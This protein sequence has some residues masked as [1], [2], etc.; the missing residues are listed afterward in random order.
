MQLFMTDTG[1]D[2]ARKDV[3]FT[4]AA[5]RAAGSHDDLVPSLTGL[6]A[7]WSAI[8]AERQ[9]HEDATEDANTFVSWIDDTLDEGVN[10][11]ATRL[12]NACN[13]D[14]TKIMF[15][16]FFP[17]TPSEIVRLGL[18]AEVTR[19]AKW[20]VV[21]KEI[22]LPAEVD[23][24][25]DD[26]RDIADRGDKAVLARDAAVTAQGAISVRTQMWR[27]EANNVRRAVE[28]ALDHYANTN[29]LARNYSA[30]FFPK[31]AAPKKK[32]AAAAPAPVPP[33]RPSQPPQ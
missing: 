13:R 17:E 3:R 14:R 23:K 4:L 33:A 20:E 16:T 25:L 28:T 24:A 31:P 18:D 22:K 2:A 19:L 12:E 6:L 7:K 21:R 30:R 1:W 32:K 8:D 27:E 26:V 9:E 29:N 15:R 11:T 5:L 10:V